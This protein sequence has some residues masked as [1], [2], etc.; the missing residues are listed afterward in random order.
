MNQ[1]LDIDDRQQT[2]IR[3]QRLR[4]ARQRSDGE[5]AAMM[6]GAGFRAFLWRLLAVTHVFET[7]VCTTAAGSDPHRTYFREGER[8]IGLMLFADV[9][10]LCPRQYPLMAQEAAQRDEELNG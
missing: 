9:H 3:A 4:L 10:R 7:S 2:G 5:F 6:E 1:P 8:N